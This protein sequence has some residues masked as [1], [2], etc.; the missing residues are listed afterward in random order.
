MAPEVIAGGGYDAHADV[1][2][3]GITAIELVEGLPPHAQM[4][5]PMSVMFR[6]VNG[7]PPQRE[8]IV[9]GEPF[10]KFLSR[11]LTKVGYRPSACLATHL[12]AH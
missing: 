6:I 5:S 2:S 3:L 8:A 1:W 11:C 12:L 7:P 9:H 4:K 10:A